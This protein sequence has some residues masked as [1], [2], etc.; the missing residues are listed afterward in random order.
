MCVRLFFSGNEYTVIP[1]NKKK[2]TK[3]ISSLFSD[4]L[5]FRRL[6]LSYALCNEIRNERFR[7]VIRVL[8]WQN[9]RVRDH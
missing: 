2:T 1:E 3:N 6:Y 5:R 4:D 9:K 8:N 7:C